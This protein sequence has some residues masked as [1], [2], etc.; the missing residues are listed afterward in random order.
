MKTTILLTFSI[1]IISESLFSQNSTFNYLDSDIKTPQTHSIKQDFSRLG[2]SKIKGSQE[3]YRPNNSNF[4]TK[5]KYQDYGY[6]PLY[7]DNG[8]LMPSLRSIKKEKPITKSKHY[9]PYYYM[10]GSPIRDAIKKYNE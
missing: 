10:P 6:L 2:S 8:A 4:K 7:L 3:L 1:L 5:I 9:A